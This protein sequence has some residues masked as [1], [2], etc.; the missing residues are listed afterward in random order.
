MLNSACGR[1]GL[2]G[3]SLVSTTDSASDNVMV[4]TIPIKDPDGW[5]VNIR[6]ADIYT[7]RYVLPQGHQYLMVDPWGSP[8]PSA[9][10]D[11]F[12]EAV[13]A[14]VVSAHHLMT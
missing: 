13:Q 9:L 14:A 6:R 3:T 2:P 12:D 10:Y 1:W 11:D 5:M 7:H 4:D 8:D